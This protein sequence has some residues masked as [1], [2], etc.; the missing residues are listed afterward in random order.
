MSAPRFVVIAGVRYRW[1]DILKLRREQKREAR[2]AQ[3][4]LFELRDDARP[5]TQRKADGRFQEPTLF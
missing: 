2:K 3:L 4:T 5:P 1:A